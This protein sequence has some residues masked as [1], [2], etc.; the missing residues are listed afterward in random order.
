MVCIKTVN[1]QWNLNPPQLP[2]ST[3]FALCLTGLPFFHKVDTKVRKH[4][5][6]CT[7]LGYLCYSSLT[8]GLILKSDE[9]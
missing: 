3:S 5:F 8:K 9:Q 7:S 1:G 2:C 6:L 4:T